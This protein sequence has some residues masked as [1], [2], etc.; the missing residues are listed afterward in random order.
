M[1]GRGG[2]SGFVARLPNYQ[3]AEVLHAK[4]KNYLLNPDKSNGKHELFKGIGYTMKNSARFERDIRNGLKN[5]KAKKFL[6]NAYGH[7]LYNVTMS[8]GIGEKADILT[9][10]QIDKGSNTPRFITAYK[11]RK[12]R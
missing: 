4:I 1:G 3:R 7:T 5:N 9:V 10:W 6:P 11:D 8:L 12:R 2:A